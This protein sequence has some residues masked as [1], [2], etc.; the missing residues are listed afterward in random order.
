MVYATPAGNIDILVGDRAQVSPSCMD[1]TEGD[2]LA[3]VLAVPPGLQ[4]QIRYMSSDGT[5]KTTWI[6]T[7]PWILQVLRPVLPQ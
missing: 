1:V 4:I 2:D 5:Q 7:N 3:M 6:D